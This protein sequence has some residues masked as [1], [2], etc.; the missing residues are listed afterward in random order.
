MKYTIRINQLGLAKS[1]LDLKDAAILDY[2][3]NFCAPDD[4]N[5]KQMSFSEGGK[6]YRYTWINFNYLI[7]EMPLLR[8]K[9][10]ASVSERIEK[11]AKEGYIKTFR[12]PDGS[13]YVRLTEKIKDLEFARGVRIGEQGVR[14]GEQVPFG[15]PNSTIK[16]LI[17]NHSGE[18]VSA[19]EEKPVPS[20]I[21]L[22]PIQQVGQYFID[23]CV[24]TKGF[25]PVVN[26]QIEGAMIKRYLREY[27]IDEL[28]QAMQWFLESKESERLGC[29]IKVAFSNY[30]FNK[31]LAQ[32]NL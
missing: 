20:K 1:I 28:R 22:T 26:W 19:L 5:V 32:R 21:P 31:W 9:G 24:Q 25:K 11:I 4:K 15:Q 16:E 8:I 29:T 17:N 23:Y 12:A 18:S 10:K 3:I 6:D 27:T 30:V 7:G 13:L 2:L 14:N